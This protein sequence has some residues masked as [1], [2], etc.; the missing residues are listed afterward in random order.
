[1]HIR[2]C[3][4]RAFACCLPAVG[5]LFGQA[6][7]FDM[8]RFFAHKDQAAV[9]MYIYACSE[10]GNNACFSKLVQDP[11]LILSLPGLL[12]IMYHTH[13]VCLHLD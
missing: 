3:N 11:D 5:Q 6:V 7:A 9:A 13:E 10:G 1:M 12:A 4:M 8:H 2:S